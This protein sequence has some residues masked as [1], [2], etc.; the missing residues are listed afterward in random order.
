MP[1][2]GRKKKTIEKKEGDGYCRKCQ[3]VRSLTNFYEATNP[4]L[5][6][7]GHFSV[8]KDC[9]NELYQ[10]YFKIYGTLDKA[11][12]LTCQDLDV[13][14]DFDALRACQAHIEAF[15]SKNRP[16]DKVFGYYKSKLT[17]VGQI[18]GGSE[19][20]RYRDGTSSGFSE[21]GKVESKLD[22]NDNIDEDVLLFWGKGFNFEDI[23]FLEAELA[24][25]KSKHK[26]DNRSELT[27]LKEICIKL[28]EIRKV[29]ALGKPT[30]AYIKELQEIMKTA[31][32]DPAKANVADGGK[33]MDAY[34]LWLKDIEEYEPAEFF[35]DKKLFHDFDGIRKYTDKYIYR[36]LKNLLSGSRDFNIDDNE[37]S[38][39]EDGDE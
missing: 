31:S 10:E 13:R 14:F 1:R 4:L 5:D 6:T 27:L 33:S 12:D 23:E 38:Y 28:L 39:D 30:G 18:N 16:V 22:K 19:F 9:C 20:C 8:C 17:S 29:R 21:T 26:C 24:E 25:W 32:V 2:V 7:N 11:L 36:P 15:M 37:T 34:G 3:R 35:E